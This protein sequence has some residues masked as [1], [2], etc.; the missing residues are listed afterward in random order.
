MRTAKQALVVAESPAGR[1]N[2]YDVY[3]ALRLPTGLLS[4]ITGLR[5]R[6]ARRYVTT[7]LPRYEERA[8]CGQNLSVSASLLGKCWSMLH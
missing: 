8:P 6:L 3:V 7:C 4:F 2:L 5:D 1:E